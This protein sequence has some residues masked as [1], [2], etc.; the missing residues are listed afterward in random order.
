MSKHT[1]GPWTVVVEDGDTYLR[2]PPTKSGCRYHS[3]MCN[4]Q[5]YPWISLTPADWKLVAAAPDLL[6][7]LYNMLEDGDATD[8]QAALAAIAKAEGENA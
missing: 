3:L 1:P 8:R 7:A 2:A 4:A 6:A 5:Y